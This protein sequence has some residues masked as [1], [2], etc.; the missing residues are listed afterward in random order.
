M[1][2]EQLAQAGDGAPDGTTP[3][4]PTPDSAP[5]ET[6]EPVTYTIGENTYS[7]DEM[8][9]LIQDAT[10][11]RNAIAEA[12][13][14]NQEASKRQEDLDR[15][16]QSER[17]KQIEE[18]Y[19]LVESSPAIAQRFQEMYGLGTGQVR[20]QGPGWD[21]A[22]PMLQHQL[23]EMQ[24]QVGEFAEMRNRAESARLASEFAQ[25]VKDEY[26]AEI[27][28]EDLENWVEKDY[29]PNSNDNVRG[30]ADNLEY[31]KFHW[32]RTNGRE[33]M[34]SKLARA[35]EDAR[36]EHDAV[37]N[38]KREAAS[39]IQPGAH[40]DEPFD[41]FLGDASFR[42]TRERALALDTNEY[43]E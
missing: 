42:K 3:E 5:V 32:G 7:E 1:S 2:Q 40:E 16:T 10:N 22:V 24:E 15:I 6:P 28:P 23:R 18:L 20:P 41:G 38:E 29:I 19:D 13:R 25:W 27:S 26:G 11:A 35:R 43:D 9:A 33:L 30:Y 8:S 17:Y 34:Q 21:P 12:T 14:R 4:T 39:G 36:K 31:M 37:E